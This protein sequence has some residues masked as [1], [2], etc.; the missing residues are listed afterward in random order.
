MDRLSENINIRYDALTLEVIEGIVNLLDKLGTTSLDLEFY[1]INFD[2]KRPILNISFDG[3]TFE[4]TL[5]MEINVVH[6][7][8]RFTFLYRFPCRD[9]YSVDF[10]EMNTDNISFTDILHTLEN[11]EDIYELIESGDDSQLSLAR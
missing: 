5:A 9:G 8:L 6:G 7:E 4:E 10:V 11:V 3:E 2:I 1:D